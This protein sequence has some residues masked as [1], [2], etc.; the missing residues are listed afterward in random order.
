M[1]FYITIV[2]SCLKPRPQQQQCQSNIV[3]CYKSNDSVD[4]V[5]RCFDIV[6][7]FCNNVEENFVFSTKSK[8]IEHVLFVSTLSKARNFTK[9]LLDIVAVC[10]A[11]KSNVASTKSNVASTLLPLQHGWL[12]GT[13]VERRSVT[14]EILLYFIILYARPAA[15]G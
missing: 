5:E 10:L 7:V 11:T 2:H 4:K 8:Q 6:A 1:L 12:R 9:N 3:E 13:V 15:D 14:G